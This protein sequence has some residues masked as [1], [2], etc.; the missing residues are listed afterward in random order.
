MKVVPGAE[1][2]AAWRLRRP[3]WPEAVIG[4]LL[5]A[6]LATTWCNEILPA[7]MQP[8]FGYVNAPAWV[9]VVAVVVALQAGRVMLQIICLGVALAALVGWLIWLALRLASPDFHGLQFDF[10]LVDLVAEGWYLGLAA[11][12]L[13]FA[14]IAARAHDDEVEPG[15]A[16][17]LSFSLIPGAGQLRLGRRFRG[18]AW[19]A[20]AV[21]MG[22]IVHVTSYN[23]LL[24][25]WYGRL[26]GTPPPLNRF[27]VGIS[28]LTLAV[29]WAGS[30][31]DAVLLDRRLRH[32]DPDI[33]LPGASPGN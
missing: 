15:T 7:H 17:V 12:A 19:L 26:G 11:L 31:V 23:Y 14:R 10:L 5:L 30:V 16:E 18:V 33:W 29:I 2:P 3:G 32:P 22:L 8:V 4:I 13:A 27:D 25:E 24:L 1:M 6:S 9:V 20:L 21:F 28:L